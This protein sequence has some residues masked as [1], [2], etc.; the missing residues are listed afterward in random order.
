MKQ[1]NIIELPHRI[2]KT[3][4]INIKKDKIDIRF[5]EEVNGLGDEVMYEDEPGK[6]PIGTECRQGPA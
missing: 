1:S 5:Y 2:N 6:E 3:S 4:Y